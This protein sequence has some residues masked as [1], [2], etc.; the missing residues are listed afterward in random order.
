MRISRV[1]VYIIIIILLFSGCNKKG[2]F[3]VDLTPVDSKDFSNFGAYTIPDCYRGSISYVPYIDDYIK[4][5][6]YLFEDN[7]YNYAIMKISDMKMFL[8]LLYQKNDNRVLSSVFADK[9]YY[10]KYF[11]DIKRGDSFI[12]IC[13]ELS[14]PE[15]YQNDNIHEFCFYLNNGGYYLLDI[16]DN[17][18]IDGIEKHKDTYHFMDILKKSKFFNIED[19]YY[20]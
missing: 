20:K 19:L 18:N 12:D 4:E 11:T 16:D 9:F 17:G 3:E 8:F 2:F 13:K 6:A 15:N 1:F 5:N 14:V 7:E 10:S